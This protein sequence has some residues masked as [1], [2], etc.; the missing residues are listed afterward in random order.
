MEDRRILKRRGWS[1]VRKAQIIGAAMGALI[2]VGVIL[3][4]TTDK[5]SDFFDPATIL[6]ILILSP[7][8][9]ICR[10]FGMS[11]TPL[12][13]PGWRECLL[14]TLVVITNAFICFLVGTCIGWL[15]EKSKPKQ[16]HD[17]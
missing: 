8:D 16:K 7:L 3:F 11:L 2:S 12:N 14:A 15:V 1:I 6:V 5:S 10:T 13:A 4:A 9:R 17:L